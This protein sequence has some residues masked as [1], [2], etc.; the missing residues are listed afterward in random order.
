MLGMGVWI[1]WDIDLERG[2]RLGG[3]T[4]EGRVD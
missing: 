4:R 3:L 1:G 2:V